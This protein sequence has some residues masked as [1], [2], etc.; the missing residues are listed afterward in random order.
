MQDAPAETLKPAMTAGEQA[1]LMA[2]AAGA[3]LAVEFGCGGSTPL[4]LGALCGPLVSVE[5]DPDWLAR[6]RSDPPC[7]AAE[8]AGRWL[9]LHGDIGPVGAWGWPQDRT[10]A[11]DGTFY[12]EA[13]WSAA[14]AP[15]FVLVDG[16]YR[17]ACGLAALRRVAP[18]GLVAVHDFWC[19]PHYWPLLRHAVLAGSVD[20]LVL[21]RPHPGTH[22]DPEAYLADPR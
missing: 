22:P 8:A 20:H 15:D 14:P 19:R 10:R 12:V 16:R 13:P 17:V 5:S 11:A 2:A 18:A 9:P 21:L 6:L 7:A 3:T 4:L 1:L